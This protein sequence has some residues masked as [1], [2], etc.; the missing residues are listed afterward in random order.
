[1]MQLKPTTREQFITAITDD[2]ADKFAKTFR[3]KADMQDQWDLCLGCWEEG[4]LMGA[5]I[6]SKSKRKP[7]VFNLQLLHTFAKHRRKGV[8]RMLVN[9]S[10][11]RAYLDLEQDEK[12]YLRV[13]AEP[14]AVVFYER[15]GFKF[16]GKQK[17][18]S[19][20]SM[21][22]LTSLSP[23]D[24]YYSTEDPIIYKAVHKKG[25]GGC[26]EVFDGN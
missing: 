8:A 20:L 24:G 21:M 16:L 13:S 17:S 12:G 3:S 26:V 11:K 18:G 4:E 1:M 7:T 9:E 2:K 10:V 15:I 14:D 23:V 19:Q 22:V 6:V 5:I 25:K